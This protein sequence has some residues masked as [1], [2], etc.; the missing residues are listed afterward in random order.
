M[1][2]RKVAQRL[3]EQQRHGEVFPLQKPFC[4]RPLEAGAPHYARQRRSRKLL[5]QRQV[6]DCVSGLN[7]LAAAS[8]DATVGLGPCPFGPQRDHGAAKAV[9]SDVSR[10]VRGVGPCPSDLT[11]DRALRELVAVGSQYTLE[12]AN[13]ASYCPDKLKVFKGVGRPKPLQK[14]LPAESAGYLRHFENQIERSSDELEQVLQSRALP[15]AHWDPLSAHNRSTRHAF[16]QKLVDHGLLSFRR[17]RKACIGIFFVHKK[18][19][20]IVY[21]SRFVRVILAQG[22]C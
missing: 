19:G 1:Q 20:D 22:P 16:F 10:R 3:V 14:F 9:V 13:L 6:Q 15:R 21:T 7:R 11:G 4:D 18:S 2:S 12:P 17:K 5:R 8:T